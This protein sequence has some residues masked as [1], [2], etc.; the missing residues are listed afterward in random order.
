M[1][2][3]KKV[4]KLSR[5]E[6]NI[7]NN[8]EFKCQHAET[9]GCK[10]VIKYENTRAHLEKECIEKIVFPEEVKIPIKIITAD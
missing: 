2:G 1:C 10:S 9:H 5:I 7:L 6:R 8:F 4:T 3:S